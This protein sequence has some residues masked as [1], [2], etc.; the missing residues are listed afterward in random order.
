MAQRLRLRL[1]MQGVYV[2]SLVRKPRSDVPQGVANIY[3]I[4]GKK[5][6]PPETSRGAIM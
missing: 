6:K 3:F 1:P 2:Q 4:K 5:K